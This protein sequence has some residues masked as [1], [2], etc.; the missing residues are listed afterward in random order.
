MGEIFL[1]KKKISLVGSLK[2]I[3]SRISKSGYE[4]TSDLIINY[5]NQSLNFK[6]NNKIILKF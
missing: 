3:F 5:L 4:I 1:K 6:N 2:N